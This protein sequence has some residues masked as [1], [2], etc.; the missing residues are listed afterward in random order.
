[1]AWTRCL[2]VSHLGIIMMIITTLSLLSTSTTRWWRRGSCFWEAISSIERGVSPRESKGLCFVP[3]KSCGWGCDLLR[4]SGGWCFPCS[5]SNVASITITTAGGHGS[6]AFTTSTA[7]AA[8]TLIPPHVSVKWYIDI[9]TTHR[10][11]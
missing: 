4:G 7:E 6:H 5:D 9:T 8:V 10:H 1:M 11:R 3:R 2:G